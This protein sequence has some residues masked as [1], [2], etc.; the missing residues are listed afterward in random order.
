M[1]FRAALR[2]RGRALRKF[3][4]RYRLFNIPYT[5]D[6][7]YIG[8]LETEIF[9]PYPKFIM[10]DEFFMTMNFDEFSKNFI[11]Y[12]KFIMSDDKRDNE[13]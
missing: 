4:F 11:Q 1:P 7:G 10:S 3:K 12:P 6:T 2:M 8:W 5:V 9:I 13:F